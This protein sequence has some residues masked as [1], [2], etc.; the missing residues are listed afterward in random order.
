MCDLPTRE[1]QKMN[2]ITYYKYHG[3]GKDLFTKRQHAHNS[4][5]ELIQVIHGNGFGMI[6]DKLYPLKDNAV[7]F[8]EPMLL[9]HTAPEKS[10]SYIRNVINVSQE[11]IKALADITGFDQTLTELAHRVCV[12][13]NEAE[14]DFLDQQFLKLRSKEKS[15]RSEALIHIL[16][17]L[18][19]IE[20]RENTIHSQVSDIVGYINKH[21]SEK[22][23]LEDICKR[24]HI[25]KYYLC[26]MFKETTG[27]SIMRYI[28]DQ[29]IAH[30]KNLM[31]RT[32]LSISEIAIRS[33]FSCF[34]YFS[35]AFKN[36]EGVSPR[37]FRK[38][39]QH[40]LSLL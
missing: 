23:V 36:A 25:S 14:A 34:S 31:I 19:K 7:F 37:A 27:M 10:E 11:H 13:V 38:R 33:G 8:V 30:A 5:V 40:K 39:Y 32:E 17:C 21:L 24:F 2:E 16:S 1:D 26:H 18:S 15:E 35:R 22:I 9:H 6:N 3:V 29:R 4:A 20:K 12:I 28:L